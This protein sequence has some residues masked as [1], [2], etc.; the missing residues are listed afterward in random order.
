VHAVTAATTTAP[1]GSW[2]TPITSELVV[3]A[4]VRLGELRVDGADPVWSEGRPAEEGRVQLVRRTPDGRTTDLLP[5]GMS[6]RTAVHEYGGAAWWVHDGVV[7]F[8]EWTD[9][10]LYRLAPGGSPQPLTPEPA[11][12]RGDRFADGDLAPDGRTMVCVRERHHGPTATEVVNEIV[13]LDAHAPSEPEVLVAVGPG[14]WD[15]GSPQRT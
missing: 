15:Q 6:A 13:R 2:P 1:Y 4:A 14:T 12:P 10:R 3:A 5:A 11:R 7:W 9:Q 8:A